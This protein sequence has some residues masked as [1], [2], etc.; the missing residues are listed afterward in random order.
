MTVQCLTLLLG[1]L[2]AADEQ[3]I[4]A[5]DYVDSQT[6]RQ[7]WVADPNTPPVEMVRDG[8]PAMLQFRAPFAADQDMPRTVIDREVQLNLSAPGEFALELD[9]EKPE[10]VGHFSLY[11][12]SGKGWYSASAG[13][14]KSGWQTLLFSKASF[15]SEG[16]PA[17]WHKIDGIR[18]S[19]W[20]GQAVDS[21]VRV[22]RLAAARHD[23]AMVIPAP[24][25]HAGDRE[26]ESA[27]SAAEELGG[28][29][30]ELGLGSDAVEDAAIPH[31][32]LDGRRLAV[33]A[34]NPRLDDEV[35]AALEQFVENGGKLFACY[36]LP[37]RLAQVLGIGRMQYF[38]PDQSGGLAEIRFDAPD[39]PGLP[40]S[41][42]QA[43]WNITVPEPSNSNAR[44]IGYW[45]D[46]QGQATGRAAML[47][48]DR[49][50]FFSHLVLSDN[51]SAKKQML[52]AILGRLSPP[53]WEQMAQSELDRVGKVGHFD[54]VEAVALHVEAAGDTQATES[55][56]AARRD[57]RSAQEAMGRDY[58]Q[59]VKLARQAHELLIDAYVRT[60]PSPTTEGRA[61][62][63]HSG[64]GAHSGDWERSAGELAE[65]GFNMVLPNMLWGGRAHYPSNV[66]PRSATYQEYG[67]QIAQCVAAAKKHRLEVHVWKVNFNLSG[68]PREF[69]DKMRSLARTQVTNSG[70]PQ[71]W[72]CPSHPDNF[73]LE[74]DSMLEVAQKYDVDGLHFDYIRYP[75]RSNCYCDGCRERF[76]AEAGLTVGDWPKDCYSGSLHDKYHDWRCSQITR[77]V[78]AVHREAKRIKPD[79]KISAAVFGSYPDCRE[80]V[81]QDWVEWIKAGYLDFVCP[82]DYT[83][84]DL[85]F[86][87]LV[88]NQ[89]RLVDGRI[90]VFPGIGAWR[91]TPDRVVG[92]IHHA[93][94]LGAAG[95]T[96]FN[97]TDEAAESVLPVVA[98]GA[99]SRQATPPHASE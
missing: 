32:A 36:C 63:N 28:M 66:L 49:G 14:S 58:P 38:K 52:A 82:M 20:R 72:L 34:Y 1:L 61:F 97:L 10:C 69:V 33:L 54:S 98:A 2:S 21:A 46:D 90:P 24:H 50:A 77:L 19:I 5:F 96:V 51:R 9:V 23:V 81:G 29:L 4:D 43:S 27:R 87:N 44:I 42:R 78:A 30:A 25:A 26:I 13:L 93:R 83:Q 73:Q 65:A 64:T 84:S 31:G 71:N 85:S 40:Q 75:G 56:A 91:L 55:L 12:R 6:A 18:I 89:L 70:E 94:E 8:G 74:L 99:G 62:W 59:V 15:R 7:Q 92:Q 16:E 41:V 39:V 86:V 22:K 88:E 79:V 47:L 57:L 11:F 45:H 35:A 53:L 37:H 48:S 3:I 95:F 76:Q 68:A 60:H 17:G 80:T 67:D